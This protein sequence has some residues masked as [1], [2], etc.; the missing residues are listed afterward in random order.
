M[1][2]VQCVTKELNFYKLAMF[3]LGDDLAGNPLFFFV[4]AGE[5]GFIFSRVMVK[6]FSFSFLFFH[7]FCFLS[8][9]LLFYKGGSKVVLLEMEISCC[10][11]CYLIL[12]SF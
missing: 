8:P 1:L 10:T 2:S 11:V 9:P 6:S 3:F 4:R 5:E 7:S 12:I